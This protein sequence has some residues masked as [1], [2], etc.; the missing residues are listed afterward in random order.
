MNL[1]LWRQT[2]SDLAAQIYGIIL[3]VDGGFVAGKKLQE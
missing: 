1:K 3:P 2:E